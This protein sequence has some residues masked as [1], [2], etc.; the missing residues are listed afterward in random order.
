MAYNAPGNSPGFIKPILLAFIAA[1]VLLAMAFLAI[2]ML[3]SSRTDSAAGAGGTGGSTFTEAVL[4]AVMPVFRGTCV[5]SAN[6]SLAQHGFDTSADGVDAKIETY[7]TC[8]T[9][10]FAS[11]LTIP[12]LLKFKLN[13]SSEPAA[14][15]IKNIMQ[16][17][18][19]KSG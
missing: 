13:P 8:A 6:A 18:Q 12:E 5:K 11:D 2:S 19:E 10:R 14:S 4:K 1:S 7:C 3:H 15:K 9:D 17:C 16:E